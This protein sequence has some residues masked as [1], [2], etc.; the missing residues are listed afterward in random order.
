MPAKGKYLLND[1]ELKN[2]A[3]YR[4][5]SCISQYQPLVLL[6]GLSM[7]SCGI[8]LILFFA[9]QLVS[10]HIYMF[11]DCYY[12]KFC[13]ELCYWPCALLYKKCENCPILQRKKGQK[14]YQKQCQTFLFCSFFSFLSSILTITRFMHPVKKA[15]HM[16]TVQIDQNLW[17][18]TLTEQEGV[19]CKI[20]VVMD[21]FTDMETHFVY[22]LCALSLP[23]VPL[24][25]RDKVLFCYRFGT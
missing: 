23:M 13:I 8:L 17:Q 5:F 1:Q 20:W 9:L 3:L 22:L 2:E 7:L 11:V 12:E 15:V 24:L 19:V 18:I 25:V 4:K 6:L 21:A 16:G 10:L 14:R